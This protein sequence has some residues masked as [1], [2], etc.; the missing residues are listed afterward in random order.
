ML[1]VNQIN[2]QIKLSEMWKA[3]NDSDH[4]FNISKKESGP[5]VRAMRSITNEVLTVLSYT[6]L[7]K[8][9]FINDGIKAWNTAPTN[10]LFYIYNTKLGPV[11][12]P[13]A[14][15]IFCPRHGKNKHESS[16]LCL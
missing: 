16:C 10:I 2:A 1:S 11:I 8:Q 7:S 13:R 6:E 3:V 5:H 15:L 9:T 14:L 12:V 4:P